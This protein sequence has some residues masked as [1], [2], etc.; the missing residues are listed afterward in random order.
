LRI[1]GP[2]LILIGGSCVAVA[3]FDFFAVFGSNAT[4]R[5]FCLGFLG[6]PLMFV[7][8][9]MTQ[10]GFLGALARFQASEMA[11]VGKDV[12][13]YMAEET[14]ESVQTVAQAAACGIQQGLQPEAN[15]PCAK[16]GHANDSGDRFC[17]GCG[18]R[19]TPD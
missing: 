13:N 17:G 11:P 2:L 1:A 18:E 10:M 7:G 6:M 4:P 12:I 9:V 5:L 8:M 16:C 14:Q 19:L 15:R 3:F